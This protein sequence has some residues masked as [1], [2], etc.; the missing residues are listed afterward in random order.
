[1]GLGPAGPRL[2]GLDVAATLLRHH[3]RPVVRGDAFRL[4][5]VDGSFDAVTVMNVLYHSRLG[6]AHRGTP[7][8]M[9][10]TRRT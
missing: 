4:P 6:A 9:S 2:I 1:M 10:P 8:A 5:F 3:P 7:D